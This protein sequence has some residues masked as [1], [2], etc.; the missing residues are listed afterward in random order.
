MNLS[1][2]SGE[3]RRQGGGYNKVRGWNPTLPP[4]N[5]RHLVYGTHYTVYKR[6]LPV[7]AHAEHGG[8]L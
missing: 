3:Y 8:F 2:N 4:I 7:F 5:S 1:I 6:S